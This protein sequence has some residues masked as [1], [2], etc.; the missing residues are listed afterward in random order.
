MELEAIKA[1][2]FGGW[3]LRKAKRLA[4]VQE[5]RRRGIHG[6]TVWTCENDENGVVTGDEVCP[7]IYLTILR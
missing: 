5:A 1:I 7:S 6:Y 4:K 2:A 3:P